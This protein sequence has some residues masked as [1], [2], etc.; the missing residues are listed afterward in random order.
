MDWFADFE[1]DYEE[2]GP[3]ETWSSPTGTGTG[4]WTTRLRS[5][6]IF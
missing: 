2:G 5:W 3:S 6:D 4:R 1:S